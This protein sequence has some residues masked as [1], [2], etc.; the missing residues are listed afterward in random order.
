VR[1]VVGERGNDVAAPE[2]IRLALARATSK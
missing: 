2:L 1:A